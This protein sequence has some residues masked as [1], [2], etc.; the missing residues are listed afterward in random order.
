MSNIDSLKNLQTSVLPN[1]S[2]TGLDLSKTISTLSNLSSEV[3][4]IASFLNNSS[5]EGSSGNQPLTLKSFA[6]E[7][8]SKSVQQESTSSNTDS[9][10]DSNPKTKKF[11][12]ISSKLVTQ[13]I[14]QQASSGRMLYLL[15]SQVNRILQQSKV[16]YVKIENGQIVAQPIQNTEINLA[17]ENIQKTIDSIVNNI[18]R[19]AKRI[20]NENP[21]NNANDL[22]NNLSLNKVVD[23]INTV[24]SIYL[25]AL[26]I[27]IKIRKSQDIAAAANAL[28]TVPPQ[29]LVAARYT[30]ASL[31]LTANEQKQLND[32][33]A[34]YAQIKN[35]NDQIVFYGRK[36]TKQKDRLSNLKGTIDSFIT[37]TT[38]KTLTQL[39]N[40]ITGSLN[41]LTGSLDKKLNN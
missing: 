23:F 4:K 22:K 18:D 8:A 11:V 15:E 26:Q 28:A 21:I 24:L 16:T 20:Y 12:Q 10:A 37:S 9:V 17:L 2:K 38:N 33:T 32:L 27:Q 29:P 31:E 3:N 13:I 6:K 41:H 7:F 25:V 30:Q 36:Y 35:L 5:V 14:N 1:T 39:N 40:Q 34:A 19:Y